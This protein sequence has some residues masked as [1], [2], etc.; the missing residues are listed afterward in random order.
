MMHAD[1]DQKFDVTDQVVAFKRSLA[2]R[3][4]ELKRAY[5]DVKD[6]VSRAAD[7]IRADTAAGRPVVPELDYNDIR[8]GKVSEATR[9]G[10]P[11]ERL[12][13]HPRRLPGVAGERLVRRGRRLSRRQSTTRSAR[14]RS[15]A[16][17]NISRP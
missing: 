6:H 5:D 1:T 7:A 13:R 14:S 12:R 10:D 11:E 3:R 2:G 4:D 16:S 17:T 8:D 15:E 9:A